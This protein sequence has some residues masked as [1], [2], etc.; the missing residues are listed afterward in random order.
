LPAA[1]LAALDAAPFSLPISPALARLMDAGLAARDALAS[2][3]VVLVPL[4]TAALALFVEE[5][6]TRGVLGEALRA[7]PAIAAARE[8]VRRR[9]HERLE[10]RDLAAAGNVAPEHLVRLFRR[11][12]GT[13]PMRYLWAER[14]RLG[15]Y[16]LE[17]TGLPLAE[18]AARAGFQTSHHFSR[19][20]RAATGLAPRE[21]RRRSWGAP[22]AQPVHT[23]PAGSAQG[24][25]AGA[26]S[27]SIS[28]AP[29]P[30]A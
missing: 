12:L 30:S 7:H 28:Q 4:V 6:R 23:S 27:P 24:P 1:H 3:R 15:V 25:A 14:V 2:P 20:V 13:T 18:V 19:L 29:L 22:A 21:V 26:T 8:L 10:L 5:A 16:L 17:H 11:D 9:L